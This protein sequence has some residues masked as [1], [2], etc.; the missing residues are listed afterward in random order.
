LVIATFH[1]LD[2]LV[3]QIQLAVKAFCKT[4]PFYLDLYKIWTVKKN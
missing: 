2:Y 1:L 3:S 4:A